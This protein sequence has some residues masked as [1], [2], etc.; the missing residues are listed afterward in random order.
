MDF[1]S[2]VDY[3]IIGGGIAGITAAE[4]IR[5]HDKVSSVSVITSEPHMLYSRVLL[6]S[7]L[8]GRIKREQ[9]FMRTIK[10]F[11]DK[12]IRVFV[13][14]EVTA[15]DTGRHEVA[16]GSGGKIGYRKLLI[17][18]GGKPKP[19]PFEGAEKLSRIFRLQTIDDADMLYKVLPGIKHALIIGGGFISLEFL[20]IFASRG[21]HA[22]LI[23]QDKN[24]FSQFVGPG[25]SEV[26]H[27][28]FEER[29]VRLV[30]GD[31][32]SAVSGADGRV[33]GVFTKK[34]LRI[35]GD[36][37]CLGIGILRNYEF[38]AG[39]GI[40]VGE[41]GILA[42]EFLATPTYGVWVAGDVAEFQDIVLGVRHA[43]GNWNN[44]F[45]QGKAAAGSILGGKTPFRNV[46]SYAITNLG[47]HI[48]VVG[49]AG[50]HLASLVRQ[51]VKPLCYEE[52]FLDNGIVKG[53]AL[54]NFPKHQPLVQAWILEQK[55]LAGLGAKIA[56]VAI[57]LESL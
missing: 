16:L 57:P 45:L 18:T 20:D 43:V 48:S 12:D 37:L 52:F 2:G 8:K 34:G 19:I 50:H 33:D 21:I 26:L 22:T 3:L 29:G 53:A 1:S 27:K 36:A 7:Y 32:I 4:T 46:A 14:E 28:N 38:L 44:A 30:T 6:P 15:I 49:D 13:G 23:C 47:F 24:F 5:E 10:D 17:A 11:D 54:I 39:S 51:S 9:L 42:D 41:K 25:G 40:T 35:Q 55:N 31:E 56:D